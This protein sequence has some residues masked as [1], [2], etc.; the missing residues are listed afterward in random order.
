[1]DNLISMSLMADAVNASQ[2]MRTL[3]NPL[4]TTLAIV[5][6]L[7]A[8]GF[9]V[10]G[11]IQMITSAG[12]PEQLAQA[13]SI[14]RNALVGLALVIAAVSITSILTNT[15]K[16]SGNT[17]TSPM[18]KLT[19]VKPAE[20]SGSLVGVLV[21]ATIGLLKNIVETAATPF[22]G[23]LSYF[24]TQTPMMA[25]NAS[26]FNLWLIILAIA[27][28]LL[29]LVVIL[30]GFNIM[31]GPSLGFDELEFKHMIPQLII[32]FILM[33]S[34]IFL[35]DIII[36][37]SNGMIQA[38]QA[39]FASNDVWE[40]LSTVAGSNVAG[41]QLA[42]LLIFIVFIILS[43]VLVIYY[44]L[45]LV[46]LYIGAVLSPLLLMLWLVPS[47]KDFVATAFRTYLTTIFVLFIH[48]VIL[49][50]AASILLGMS[51]GNESTLDPVMSMFVG[52]ATILALLK[53]QSVLSQFAYVS[54]GARAMRKLGGQFTNGVSSMTAK[55]RQ[56]TESKKTAPPVPRPTIVRMPSSKGNNS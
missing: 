46:T 39:G 51:S 33:N 10:N 43:V 2:T 27:N 55:V 7:V 29:I 40:T 6:G 17:T 49:A 48:V 5:A 20:S 41:M 56:T 54:T 23:A 47:F 44:I 34:S 8:A 14:I 32:V 52:I 53:T 45:R 30:L 28:V 37:I 3:I 21:N 35:I 19:E 50:L 31:S 13:K 9:L 36:S 42:A 1:M 26:V 24:T 38:L 11:G 18:P 15:Y 12:K 4:I 22:I 16:A 25:K